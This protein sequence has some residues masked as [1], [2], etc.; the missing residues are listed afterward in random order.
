VTEKDTQDLIYGAAAGMVKELDPFSQFMNST[1]KLYANDMR[2][3]S[4]Y[5]YDWNDKNKDGNVTSNELSMVN[6]GGSWGTVQELRVSEPNSK[7]KNTP[8]VGVYP[9][10]TRYSY[11]TGDTK[12]NST[13]MDYTL[14]ASFYKKIDW[15]DVWVNSNS[16]HVLP[17]STSD[18]TATLVVPIDSKPGVYQGFISF[19]SDKHEVN[20]PVSFGV[21]KKIQGKDMPTVIEG[22]KDVN[23]LY[24]NGYVG[25]AFDMVNRYN[26]G[27]WRQYY[28]DVQDSTINALALNISWENKDTN[29]AVFV[30][31]PLGKI[32]QTNVPPGVLG[33]FQGWP[34]GD[35]LGTTSFS[36]G[37]GFFPIKNKDVTST[38]LYAPINQTG[39]YSVLMHSTLFGGQDVAEPI[40]V[41][42]KFSTMLPDEKAPQI[43]LSAPEFINGSIFSYSSPLTQYWIGYTYD[44][45]GRVL[46][47]AN[48]DSSFNTHEYDNWTETVTDER[49]CQMLCSDLISNASF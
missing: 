8:L 20:A 21:K 39:T 38:V 2:I 44:P 40:T 30:I 13:S 31:D 37:G 16:I 47:V 7:I 25:G 4:L 6:R 22:S 1:E 43:L 28:F 14:T 34:T 23:V 48:S 35:W 24:G 36:E 27:D 26:A 41:T 12:K 3:S 11:W 46:L 49:Y 29:L 15:T 19:K 32:I 42:A 5:F 45:M 33:Q 10:P 9:V 18:V 17:H